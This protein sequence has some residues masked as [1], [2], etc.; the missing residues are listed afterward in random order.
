[1]R[2]LGAAYDSERICEYTGRALYQHPTLGPA[3][4]KMGYWRED[5]HLLAT[6]NLSP[7]E[8]AWL[9]ANLVSYQAEDAQFMKWLQSTRKHQ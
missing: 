8:M 3:G 9:S 7:E 4:W 1:M 5:G 2:R 6:R